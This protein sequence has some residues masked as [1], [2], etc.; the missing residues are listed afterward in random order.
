MHFQER[1]Q[2]LTSS[3]FSSNKKVKIAFL[4]QMRENVSVRMPENAGQMWARISPNTDT[5]CA[6][7]FNYFSVISGLTQRDLKIIFGGLNL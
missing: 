1:S 6:V 2:Y 3:P 5:F 7:L 4:V